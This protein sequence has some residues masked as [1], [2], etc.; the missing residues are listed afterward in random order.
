MRPFFAFNHQ[1]KA[2]AYVQALTS[3][4]WNEVRDPGQALF[5][6]SDI[7]F[8]ARSKTLRDYRQQGK[9]IFLYSHAARPN[10]FWDFP[11]MTF[12]PDVDAYFLAAAGHVEI[13]QAICVPYPMHVVGWHLC[14][15][16]AF[17][18]RDRVQRILYAPI[19]PNSNGFLCRMDR[20]MNVQT[21]KK[22]LSLMTENVTLTVRHLQGLKANGLWK[23]GGVDYIEGRPDLTYSQIDAADLV[24]SHQTFAFLAVAR[25][26]PTLMM[27]E[28]QI[29]R[30]GGSEEKLQ[31]TRSWDKYKHLLMYPLDVLA[32]E[33]VDTL[34]QR[35]I[36]SDCE[37]AQWR[38]RMIGHPFDGDRF[39]STLESYL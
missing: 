12:S 38:E 1:G 10:I 24:V 3:R 22:L 15:I 32:E 6:L 19:H 7:D 9:K 33:D 28:W 27:G 35:A 16:K 39:V 13:S 14:P 2:D 25:G 23:A 34:V 36:R 5:I 8:H 37:I 11:D 18:P 29:P 30:W 17:K 4:G 20:E 31:F 26:T 21:F